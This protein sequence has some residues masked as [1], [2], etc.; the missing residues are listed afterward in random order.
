MKC[1]LFF[2]FLLTANS[3]FAQAD[4]A[5]L[6][7]AYARALD[8]TEAQADSIRYYADYIA[9]ATPKAPYPVGKIHGLRLYGYYYENKADFGKAIDFYLQSLYEAR[10]I[11][12]FEDE[13]SA[14]TDLAIVYTQDLRQPEKAK[15]VY[16]ECVALN[17]KRGDATSLIHT[18]N[19]LGAIY[20]KLG[21]YDSALVFLRE[22]LQIGKPLEDQ[23]K[24]DLSSLYNNFGN[25]YFYRKQ[26][27]QA[28]VYFRDNYRHHLSHTDLPGKDDLWLDALNLADT[29]SEMNSFDS[30]ARYAVLSIDLATQLASLSKESDSYEILSKVYQ[31][32]GD[33]KKKLRERENKIPF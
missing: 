16:L 6:N 14:L 17:K 30:A 18:Y 11:Q 22:G 5:D 24:E 26:F 27:S 19:N 21:L 2:L 23:G 3:I 12:D 32:K 28:L 33:Y 1:S 13:A 25:T 7:R 20:N 4:T 8:L 29:Y 15:G 9:R 10:K 31:R